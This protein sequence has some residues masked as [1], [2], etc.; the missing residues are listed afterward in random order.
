VHYR[1]R[2]V[3][4]WTSHLPLKKVVV[5]ILRFVALVRGVL[6]PPI[7]PQ[8]NR[9]RTWCSAAGASITLRFS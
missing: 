4:N 6:Y 1:Y 5:F 2:L 3:F 8:Y 9:S 7:T